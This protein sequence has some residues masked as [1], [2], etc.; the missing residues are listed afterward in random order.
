[1]LFLSMLIT[2]DVALITFVPFTVML[3]SEAGEEKLL[4]PVIVLETVAANMGSC[5]T[6]LGN[7]QNLFLYSYTGM[8]AGEFMQIMASSV[9]CSF[10]LLLICLFLLRKRKL[11][12]LPAVALPR[13]S[14]KL[15]T[16]WCLLF[17]LCILSVLR[18]IPCFYTLGIVILTVAITDRR[19][20]RKADYGLLLTFLCFFIFIGNLKQMP[21]ISQQLTALVAGHELFWGIFASQFIS[22]VPAAI[23]LSG[24]AQNSAGLLL[25]VNIGGLGTLIASMASLISYKIYAGSDNP[26]IGR[27]LIFFTAVNVLFLAIVTAVTVVI[28]A[29]VLSV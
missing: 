10:L 8:G 7:P 9:I 17:F 5:F 22:N 25:G 19:L 23:L 6:P 29:N 21:L 1:M 27:Y 24:Y 18:I 4:I 15:A 26:H 11:K 20:L 28:S 3:L 2:N 13:I 16:L 12:Q 14:A